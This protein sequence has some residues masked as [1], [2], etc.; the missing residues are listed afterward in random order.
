[1]DRAFRCFV[2][3]A[4]DAAHEVIEHVKPFEKRLAG[5]RE[6]IGGLKGRQAVALAYVLESIERTGAYAADIAEL[7]INQSVETSG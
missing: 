3:S 1:L 6:S 7:A 2:G 5:L 4:G